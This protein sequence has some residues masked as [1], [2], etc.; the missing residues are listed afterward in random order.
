MTDR[1]RTRADCSS[2][3]RPCPYVSCRHHLLLEV[4]GP[5]IWVNYP[6]RHRLRDDE[7]VE[8]VLELMPFSCS[9]DAAEDGPKRLEE[10]AGMF[11]VTRQGAQL[12][13][14]AAQKKFRL[15]IA[16]REDEFR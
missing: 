6:R 5:D 11:G 15:A 12:C 2:I 4:R 1:P 13:E 8:D 9:L 14:V 3:P 10:V 16:G 7:P